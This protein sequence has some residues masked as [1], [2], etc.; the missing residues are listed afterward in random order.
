MWKPI[1]LQVLDGKQNIPSPFHKEGIM[2]SIFVIVDNETRLGYLLIWCS[3]TL[4]G[5]HLSRLKVPENVEFVTVGE[6]DKMKLPKIEF[7]DPHLM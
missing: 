4:K 6:F 7:V 5:V 1:I 2:K 3:K